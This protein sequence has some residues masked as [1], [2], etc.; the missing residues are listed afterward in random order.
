MSA[1]VKF[2]YAVPAGTGM[3]M[4]LP[5][6]CSPRG[7]PYSYHRLLKDRQ[8]DLLVR[9]K[10]VVYVSA[11]PKNK[12]I[13]LLEVFDG[14]VL[15]GHLR[16]YC[17][18]LLFIPLDVTRHR[19]HRA[20]NV[21]QVAAVTNHATAIKENGVIHHR[22][23]PHPNNPYLPVLARLYCE[24]SATHGSVHSRYV[25]LEYED[26]VEFRYPRNT[27]ITLAYL[28]KSQAMDL[29]VWLPDGVISSQE[30]AES[31]GCYVT[32]SSKLN[33]FFTNRYWEELPH[34]DT[35]T[36]KNTDQL[37]YSYHLEEPLPL[38]TRLKALIRRA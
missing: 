34:M 30:I 4:P 31:N 7:C 33:V 36:V 10:R 23:A 32:Y 8:V 14:D 9:L 3:M 35:F 1:T 22:S 24:G 20:L 18:W 25:Y 27:D 26:H 11:Y 37:L 21:E 16:S 13:V 38:K 19:K 28:D 17:G 15:L 29:R 5:L 12:P 2:P 6:R